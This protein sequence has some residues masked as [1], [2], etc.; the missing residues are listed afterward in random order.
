VCLPCTLTGHETSTS[1][2]AISFTEAVSASP[3][4][5]PSTPMAVTLDEECKSSPGNASSVFESFPSSPTVQGGTRDSALPEVHLDFSRLQLA[6]TPQHPSHTS[7]G[8]G[9]NPTS[10]PAQS[11][12]MQHSTMVTAWGGNQASPSVGMCSSAVGCSAGPQQQHQQKQPQAAQPQQVSTLTRHTLA[13]A[14][15]PLGSWALSPGRQVPAPVVDSCSAPASPHLAPARQP[16]PSGLM[17]A[18]LDSSTSPAAVSSVDRVRPEA[19][20]PSDSVD[21]EALQ[22]TRAQ[23]TSSSCDLSA[24]AASSPASAHAPVHH[25][26]HLVGAAAGSGSYHNDE[27]EPVPVMTRSVVRRG[28]QRRVLDSSS[29]SDCNE[30]QA[31]HAD[32]LCTLKEQ[33]RSQTD[34]ATPGVTRQ[35]TQ[36]G[37]TVYN[38]DSISGSALLPPPPSQRQLLLSARRQARTI[39]DSDDDEEEGDGLAQGPG[40]L[41]RAVQQAQPVHVPAPVPASAEGSFIEGPAIKARGQRRVVLL[42]PPSPPSPLP[43]AT[44]TA[45][46]QHQDHD[47][48]VQERP[49]DPLQAPWSCFKP[50]AGGR[51][52]RGRASQHA[53]GDLHT[54]SDGSRSAASGT[55]SDTWGFNSRG[56]N[57]RRS[58]QRGRALTSGVPRRSGS[59]GVDV[60]EVASSSDCVGS[61]GSE[62]DSAS[63]QDSKAHSDSDGTVESDSVSV[64]SGG[65]RGHAQP[66]QSPT[67]HKPALPHLPQVLFKYSLVSGMS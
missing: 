4:V 10:P 17:A 62:E 67:H 35:P 25:Q 45:A 43:A 16:S 9:T 66:S 19:L 51:G 28:T 7:A 59:R 64:R 53:D 8:A 63:S 23:G 48:P 3:L 5:L 58:N 20:F 44:R 37:I 1:T 36:H 39:L 60:Y 26:L 6:D 41:G 52:T 56:P 15:P 11:S 38:A 27:E 47:S 65:R 22:S 21:P 54:D 34:S 29:D 18:W 14:T 13:A 50:M 12:P 31:V 2:A 55:G 40:Q 33:P 61:F 32:G 46:A 57:S 24:A 42:L 30:S 49:H